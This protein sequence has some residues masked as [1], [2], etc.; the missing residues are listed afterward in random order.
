VAGSLRVLRC[1]VLQPQRFVL[2]LQNVALHVEH[3]ADHRK[4][5]KRKADPS[6]SILNSENMRAIKTWG[7]D[8][9]RRRKL[10]GRGELLELPQDIRP[11]SLQP[12]FSLSLRCCCR[13][14]NRV[15]THIPLRMKAA[16]VT[17]KHPIFSA[18]ASHT[19]PGIACPRAG[20]Q[21]YQQPI[22]LTIRRRCIMARPQVHQSGVC[23]Y[24]KCTDLHVRAESFLSSSRTA[25]VD[26]Q[27][28][29]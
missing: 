10:F 24:C 4:D 28:S 2:S 23:R 18:E 7:T 5:A 8:M 12:W 19:V 3:I 22:C 29:G 1:S 13:S 9:G 26:V 15:S 21:S 25:G 11:M 6:N 17:L 27:M 14:R 20:F 16:Q